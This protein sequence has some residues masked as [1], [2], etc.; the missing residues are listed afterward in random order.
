MSRPRVGNRRRHAHHG[1]VRPLH[2]EGLD[3]EVGRQGPARPHHALGDGP[4]VGPQR[5]PEH[6]TRHLDPERPA[7]LADR[8]HHDGGL[9]GLAAGAPLDPARVRPR[10]L[11]LDQAPGADGPVRD[12]RPR[13]LPERRRLREPELPQARGSGVDAGLRPRLQRLPDRVEQCRR[14]AAAPDRGDAVLGRGGDGQGDRPLL[15]AGPQ[16]R[17]L[18]AVAAPLRGPADAGGPALGAGLERG[19]GPGPDHQLPH[20]LR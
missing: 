12:L 6:G 11:R 4:A 13:A 19:R 20:R 8:H 3:Q 2:L 9:A 16:G 15:Q 7:V 10:R 5:R 14:E 17:A 18:P 1:A